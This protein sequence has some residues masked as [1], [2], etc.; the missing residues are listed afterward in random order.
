MNLLYAFP[1]FLPTSNIKGDIDLK[2][3]LAILIVTNGIWLLSFV[4]ALVHNSIINR[5]RKYCKDSLYVRDYF[6]LI[7]LFCGSVDIT[8]IFIG[9]IYWVFTLL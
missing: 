7:S 3:I 6:R 5:G 4:A 2:I 8:F 9:L 1:I